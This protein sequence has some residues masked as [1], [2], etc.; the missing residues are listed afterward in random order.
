M[1]D[2]AAAPPGLDP[3]CLAAFVAFADHLNF[4]RAAAALHLSQPAVHG[5]VTRLSDQVGAALYRRQGR[6]LVLTEAGR[7]V[8]AFARDQTARTGRLLAD[9]RGARDTAP[10]VLAAGEG[11][12]LF[13]LGGAL[14]A[15]H[16]AGLRLRLQVRDAEGALEA[17]RTAEADVAV[18]PVAA[19][20]PDLEAIARWHVGQHVVL[21][22]TH[23]LAR[24]AALTPADLA[25]E[26]LVVGP[27]G[28]PHRAALEAALDGLPWRVAVEATGWPLTLRFV[29]LGVGLAVV[30]DCCPAPAG[31]TAVPFPALARRTFFLLRRPDP[32]PPPGAAALWHLLGARA[33]S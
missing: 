3:T 13:L 21:P 32:D 16:D 11:S 7:A 4:T 18:A 27:P 12:Y 15:A 6:R 23:P 9:L 1:V 20:P 10:T 26:A 19:P 17:V 2:P 28:G 8:L 30:N 14:R 33:R 29:A 5:Q 31:C 25:G 22:T 24:R